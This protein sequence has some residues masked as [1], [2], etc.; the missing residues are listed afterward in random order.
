MDG[1]VAQRLG[2]RLVDEAVLVEQRE[3]V[4][5]WAR[6]G[7]LEVVAAAGPVLDVEHARVGKRVAEKRFEP[8]GSHATM[9]DA[10]AEYPVAMAEI[11]LFPLGIVLLPTELVPLHI[12]EDR[13]KELIA[14]CLEL[15]GSSG[16]STRTRTVCA[17]SARGRA[18]P[19]CW[20]SSTTAA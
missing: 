4:E 6:H 10:R 1:A 18:W 13:Y 20:R 16:S 9:L 8:F 7:H 15:G 2:E 19:R 11:G 17:R 3:P 12:F 14:E 5:A